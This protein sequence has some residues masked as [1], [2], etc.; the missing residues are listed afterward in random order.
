GGGGAR[1]LVGNKGTGGSGGGG[2]GGGNGGGASAGTANT[3]G[4]GGGARGQASEDGAAGG[5]GVVII[6]APLGAISS[7]SGGTHTTSGSNDIWT[8]TSSGSWTVSG[9]GTIYSTSTVF[10]TTTDSKYYYDSLP[11]GQ[12]SLGNNT[13]QEDWVSGT[14][15]ASSTKT[16]NSYGLIATS[17]DRNGNGTSYVY[18]A[19]NLFAATS[20]NPLLQKTQF[21]YNYSNG[22]V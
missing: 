14:T 15:Y 5:S 8:F 6:A 2:S 4:G 16:Y 1:T 17:T 18:D 10:S 3:G 12:V 20:T 19:Y 13:R 11:F 22:K 7:A 21:Y 9:F